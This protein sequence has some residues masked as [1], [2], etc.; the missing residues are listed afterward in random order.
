MYVCM[1]ADDEVKKAELAR[2]LRL[3][4]MIQARSVCDEAEAVVP[5]NIW[6]GRYR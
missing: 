6:V 2:Q 1:Q 4:T 5:A 3:E